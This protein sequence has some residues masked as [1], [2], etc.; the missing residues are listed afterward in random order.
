MNRTSTRHRSTRHRSE[1]P[2]RADGAPDT[3]SRFRE[4]D[5]PA[6]RGPVSGAV[7]AA[8][9]DHAAP[10]RVDLTDVDPLGEDAQLALVVLQEL[11][12]GGWASVDPAREW[13]PALVAIRVELEDRMLAVIDGECATDAGSATGEFDALLRAGPGDASASDWLRMRG[14]E[15][16]FADYFA[17]RSLYHLKEADPHA[18]AIPRLPA[19]AKAPFVAV[20]YDEYG[21]GQ[22]ER[23][24]QKLYANLLIAFGLDAGYLRYLGASPAVVLAPVTLMT[25]LG[26]RRARRGAVV[27]HFAATEVT[28]SP[29]SARLL[30]GLERLGAP[31]PVRLFYREHVEA[32]A[33]HELVMRD[34]VVA[35]LLAAEPSLEA[36]V[37]A[38]IRAFGWVEDRLEAAFLTAWR[39]GETLLAID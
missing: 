31:E 36:D 3:P 37:V 25:A 11:H 21:G 39:A 5:L 14:T 16:E 17:A 13:D 8:L 1:A 23:V 26:L 20:E 27:G 15:R 22:T 33:V 18:W 2:S 32:D 28:S 34:E 30:A 6:P 10:R 29:G 35:G 7:I 12:Y 4:P 19:E 9:T 38:G 24:H